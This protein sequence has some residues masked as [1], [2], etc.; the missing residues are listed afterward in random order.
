[1]SQFQR[2]GAILF[3][4]FAVTAWLGVPGPLG[5]LAGYA[6]A[7]PVLVQGKGFRITEK[8][9]AA[10][11]QNLPLHAKEQFG[12]DEG[13]KFLLRELVRIEVFA[14]EARSAGIEKDAVFQA[15]LSQVT[16]AL[17][18]EE[19]TKRKVLSQVAKQEDAKRYFAEHPLEFKIPERIKAPFIFIAVPKG[20]A[21][22][23]WKEKE[24]RANKIHARAARGEDFAQLMEEVKILSSALG[25][26]MQ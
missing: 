21:A 22:E 25:R 20:A 13:K 8:D 9:L 14:R 4:T 19:Y 26:K 15:K 17:L 6:A 11:V 2:P 23:T 7:E 24:T 3:L 1:M 5:P 10:K 18:A 12:N 16:N